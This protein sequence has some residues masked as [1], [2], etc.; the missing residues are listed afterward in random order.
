MKFDDRGGFV[1]AFSQDILKIKMRGSKVVAA[2]IS[3]YN[4]VLFIAVSHLIRGSIPQC[5][6]KAQR[7]AVDHG[8]DGCHSCSQHGEQVHDERQNHVS[9]GFGPNVLN[10][11]DSCVHPLQGAVTLLHD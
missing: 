9:L 5:M 7:A 6:L 3:Y 1:S 11:Q 10:V 4:M 8:Q 2:S